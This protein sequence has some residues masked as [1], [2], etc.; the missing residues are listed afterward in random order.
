ME[1]EI[2]IDMRNMILIKRS[3][4]GGAQFYLVLTSMPK[5]EIVELRVG[6]DFE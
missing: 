2:N 5:G 1:K 4:S 3:Y 6:I